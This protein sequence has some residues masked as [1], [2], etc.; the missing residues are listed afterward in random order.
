MLY[1]KFKDSK[2]IKAKS[3]NFAFMVY[4]LSYF[5]SLAPFAS[6]T[7]RETQEMVQIFSN[8]KNKFDYKNM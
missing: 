4:K 1:C 3:R 8:K 6:F 7:K 2:W 5:S